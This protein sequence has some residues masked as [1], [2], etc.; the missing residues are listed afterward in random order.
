MDDT[1][2]R[3]LYLVV[4]L[5][6]VGGWGFAE[7]RSRLGEGMRSLLAWGLIVMGLMAGYGIY[8]EN[9][10]SLRPMMSVSGA[11]V[12]IPRAEDGH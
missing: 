9:A 8:Q 11:Q 3:A 6:A 12:H 10:K 7:Y 1:Y 2:I 4:I 5:V